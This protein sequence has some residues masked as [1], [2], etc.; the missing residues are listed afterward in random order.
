MLS[1]R[2]RNAT[3]ISWSTV[4]ICFF[5][6]LTEVP[7]MLAHLKIQGLAI[8]DSLDIDFSQGFNVITGE[9]GAGK[10]ILIKALSLLLGSKSSPDSVRSGCEQATVSGRFVVKP[11]HPALIMLK[12]L[13]VEAEEDE[14]G[15][16][17]IVRRQVTAKGRTSAWINDLPVTTTTLKQLSDHLID[18]FGQHDNHRL[19][20][21]AF[22][23]HYL[24][25]FLKDKE[26][27]SKLSLL[28]KKASVSLAEIKVF[29][30]KLR[31]SGPDADYLNFVVSELKQ[32]D[33]SPE[34]FD[35]I[36]GQQER[37]KSSLV[38]T[39]AIQKASSSLEDDSGQSVARRL[40]EASRALLSSKVT[41]LSTIGLDANR[42][43]EQV[44]ELS[45]SLSKFANTIDLTDSEID[46]VEERIA[47]YQSLFRKHQCAAVQD[48]MEKWSAVEVQVLALSNAEGHIAQLVNHF[49]QNVS[50]LMVCAELLTKQRNDA[51]NRICKRVELELSELAMPGAR[52][53]VDLEPVIRGVPSL[54]L[55]HYGAEVNRAWAESL[56]FWTCLSEHGQEK[57]QFFLSSN[58]GEP[59]L[60][61]TKIASGGEIS[62]IMLA[63]KK[64]L[65]VGAETCV[66]V[67]D[68]I[69]SGISGRI[70]DTVGRKIAELADYCQIIC[71][72]HLPQVAAYA[73]VHYIVEKKQVHSRTESNIRPLNEIERQQELARLLSGNKVNA[74]GLKN[75]Q[76]LVNEAKL[77][78]T[79]SRSPAVSKSPAM[80]AAVKRKRS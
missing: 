14:L 46:R 65:V 21:V 80:A 33:P 19:L 51:V 1:R 77:K 58:A 68:E 36:R 7:E 28:Y 49:H 39:Q 74:A 70:A 78:L 30:E 11:N 72:S 63:L 57:A 22:H 75:A 2:L 13:G 48:L 53:S 52:F 67:F 40:R 79:K 18:V 16:A 23:S 56:D 60:P 24:D 61:L 27:P 76:D 12:E 8:I 66:L 37:A 43:A 20:D 32:F 59:S 15:F 3:N 34:D 69:D 9:T 6:S 4:G 5:V 26:L 45:Y 71:I 62:R 73:D 29:V 38:I 10:S 55:S 25:Q 41:E 47:G 31:G 50:E 17:I 35:F 42:L 64:A 44:D 54:D